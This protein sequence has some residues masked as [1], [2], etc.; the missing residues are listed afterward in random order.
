MTKSEDKEAESMGRKV[1][2]FLSGLFAS[3]ERLLI[4]V[5]VA[6][7]GIDKGRA[8]FEPKETYWDEKDIAQIIQKSIQEEFNKPGGKLDRMSVLMDALVKT[9]SKEA[10]L[11]IYEELA[12]YDRRATNPRRETP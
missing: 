8:Y 3:K 2:A 1:G 11:A 9:Q 6:G 4:A 10:R 5:L 12:R 7:F